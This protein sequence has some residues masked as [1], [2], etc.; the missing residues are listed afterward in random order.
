MK[1]QEIYK[2]MLEKMIVKAENNTIQ[3]SEQLVK[4]LITEISNNNLS[5][6][7]A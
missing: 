4:A 7:H 3:T 6:H 5:P 1:E 2:R